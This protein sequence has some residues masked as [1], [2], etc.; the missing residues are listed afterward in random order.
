MNK[1]PYSFPERSRAGMI[2]AIERIA[3][4]Y[5]ERHTGRFLFSWNVKLGYGSRYNS[6]AVL[7]QYADSPL[8]SA[9]DDAWQEEL[10]S[11]QYRFDWLV[12]VMRREVE[13]YSTYPG[14]DQGAFEFAFCGR[15]GGHMCLVSAFGQDMTGD[16]DD[17]CAALADPEETPFSDLRR[18]YR[19]LVCME[20]DFSPSKVLGAYCYALA[21]QRSQWEEERREERKAANAAT[22]AE[23]VASRPDM[24]GVEA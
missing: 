18:L 10:E 9:L 8:D 17:F 4:P 11:N 5:Y 6:A 1:A 21:F 22:A 24:Y 12:E 19:A 15:Q 3:S 20:Q 13:D 16:I 7:N 23:Y 14:T 2:R